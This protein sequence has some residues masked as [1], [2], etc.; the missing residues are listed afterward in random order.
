M[1]EANKV[2]DAPQSKDEATIHD[3]APAVGLG[4]DAN[5]FLFER[6]QVVEGIETINSEMIASGLNIKSD[7]LQRNVHRIVCH[8]RSSPARGNINGIDWI[9]LGK[10]C[11]SV[12][13]NNELAKMQPRRLLALLRSITGTTTVRFMRD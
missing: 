10:V 11:F 6:S 13:Y 4:Q 5:I 2:S 3:S 12:L 1:N 9:N 8:G 7:P